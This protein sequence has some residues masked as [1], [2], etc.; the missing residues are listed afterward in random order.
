MRYIVIL[1]LF[2]WTLNAAQ[3][4]QKV[5]IG[6]GPYIQTQPYKDADAIFVPSPV[7][8]FDNALF[9][10][11]WSRFGMYFL[12]A[13][14]ENYAWGF[15]LTA[16]PRT[17]GYKASDSKE[18]KGMDERKTTFEGG[19]AFSASIGN[20]YIEMMLLSDMFNRYD[21]WIFKTEIGDEY[22]AGNFSFYPSLIAIY[23]SQK[24]LNYYYGVKAS[25][26]TAQ[27]AAYTPDDGV[28]FGAQTYI[29]YPLTSKLSTLI[30]VRADYIPQTAYAS[31]I[32]HDKFIYS[33]LISLI[34]TFE[35]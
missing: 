21:S 33:G 35:Y 18:L 24:F 32:V 29:E 3:A 11:R 17:Y 15:S 26:A 2:A 9:Y 5:T 14:H 12:G 27:R 20:R 25:E 28:L 16:Q 6:I 19:L 31:P 23:Q 22:H 30:N 8:F 34:Y 7:I 1:V 10:I 13:K 4:K